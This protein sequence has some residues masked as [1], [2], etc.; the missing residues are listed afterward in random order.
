MWSL[1]ILDSREQHSVR[2][3]WSSSQEIRLWLGPRYWPYRH[4]SIPANSFLTGFCRWFSL[5]RPRLERERERCF[6]DCWR[7]YWRR[8]NTLQSFLDPGPLLSPSLQTQKVAF[9]FST[10]FS[11]L[12][13]HS[14]VHLTHVLT[15]GLW[16]LFGLEF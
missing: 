2:Q 8:I 16:F 10:S 7:G 14:I 12:F 3:R 11:F 1:Q 9:F 6:K 4:P 5:W 15:Y 13:P